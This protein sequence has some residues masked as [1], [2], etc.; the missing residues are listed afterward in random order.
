VQY[1]KDD[2]ALGFGPMENGI[3]EARHER[4]PYLAMNLREHLWIVFDGIEDRIDS[5]KKA[6]TKPLRLLFVV[7]KPC[8]QIPPNLPT[9]DNWQLH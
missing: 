7:I 3:R 1:S 2:R 9:V 8:S 4:P 5:S 6:L